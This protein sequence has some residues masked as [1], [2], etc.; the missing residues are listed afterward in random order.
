[1]S[2]VVSSPVQFVDQID[3]S[4]SVEGWQTD[5]EDEEDQ[6]FLPLHQ[7]SILSVRPQQCSNYNYQ[8]LLHCCLSVV[9]SSFAWENPQH[10]LD[11]KV[12]T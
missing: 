6:D 12:L 2:T 7:V 10:M 4:D 11:S 8:T 9:L 5:V 1:M 3:V